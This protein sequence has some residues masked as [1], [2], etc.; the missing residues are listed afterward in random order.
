MFPGNIKSIWVLA[1]KV[2]KDWCRTEEYKGK[3]AD[4][5]QLAWAE[6]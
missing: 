6:K 5:K 2:S 4:T 1:E 3:A